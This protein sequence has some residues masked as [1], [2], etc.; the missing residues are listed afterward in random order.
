MPAQLSASRAAALVDGFERRP[1]YA[2]LAGA[3]AVAIGDGRIPV[4]TRLPSERDLAVALDVSRTTATRAYTEL[5]ERGYAE[6]RRGSGTYALIPGGRAHTLDRALSPR[7]DDDDT[8]DLNCAASSAPPGL[9]EAYAA[10]VD[11][12]PA[13]LAGHGY[14]PAGLP[15]LQARLAAG[16]TDRG[17][18]TRPEQVLVTSGALAAAAVIARAVVSA[19][20][21]VV[22]ETPGYP[23]APQSFLASGARLAP[24]PVDEHGWD[25]DLL[26]SRLRERPRAAYLV[27]DFQNPTGLLMA[28]ADRARIGAELARAGTVTVVDETM[29]SLSLEGRSMPL[30]LAAHVEAAGGEALTVGGA[31]KSFWGGLRIGWLRAPLSWIDA[32]TRARLTLDLG[33][34]VVEQL[35][36]VAL[37]GDAEMLLAWHRA[38]LR[39]QRDALARLLAERLPDWEVPVPA[40]GLA[41]WCGLPRPAGV[42]LAAEAEQ[43]GVLV[44]PGP[45]F[46]PEGGYAGRV[47]I[48]YTRPVAQLSAAVD[49]LAD[50]W[51]A[52]GTNT[53]GP[54]RRRPLVA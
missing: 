26:G 45:V 9:A 23:N 1:A 29:Q 46:A 38:R 4:G 21:R 2:G 39:D 14:Y 41:L 47:R 10:A 35:A 52:V 49:A 51:E 53:D 54:A 30:P 11:Q 5:C 44:T 3:L 36:L 13:Y 16:F 40:G 48:P 42:P 25:A 8:I 34:P 22:V 17:L 19:G 31:S 50:A 24:V 32:L 12:L 20:D 18:P 27:P 15:A 28:D 33:A 6:A 43:R 37:L 7:A